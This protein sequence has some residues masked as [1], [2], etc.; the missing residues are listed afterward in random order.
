M[1]TVALT[2]EDYE[3]DGHEHA[4]CCCRNSFIVS[5]NFFVLRFGVVHLRTCA[6]LSEHPRTRL[7]LVVKLAWENSYVMLV[8]SPDIV[9]EWVPW[10]VILRSSKAFFHCQMM[11]AWK[12]KLTMFYYVSHTVHQDSSI[13]IVHTSWLLAFTF[14][15]TGSTTCATDIWILGEQGKDDRTNYVR[16]GRHR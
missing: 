16:H 15:A 13:V 4:G 7:W 10:S 12:F 11:L 3:Y 5:M 9:R 1:L 14:V 6:H 2:C 8:N